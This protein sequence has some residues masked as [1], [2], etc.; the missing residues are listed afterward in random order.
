MKKIVR[1]KLLIL[2]ELFFTVLG[3]LLL[4]FGIMFL[5]SNCS[6]TTSTMVSELSTKIDVAVSEMMLMQREIANLHQKLNLIQANLVLPDSILPNRNGTMDFLA[7]TRSFDLSES[8]F[9][10]N[11]DA[12]IAIVEFTDYECPF[13]KQHFGTTYGQIKEQY[14]DTGM[15]RYY[16]VDFPLDN[17]PFA[18]Q[19]AIAAHCAGAQGVYWN[20]HDRL[21]S[22]R[23]TLS[24]G[25]F[26]EIVES[27]GLNMALFSNCSSD[28][29]TKSHIDSLV[30]EAMGI[31]VS[32]T[33][34]FLIGEVDDEDQ[35]REGIFLQGARPFSAFRDLISIFRF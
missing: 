32:G 14:V 15:A 22:A 7:S 13:C 1:T 17:H 9:Q 5:L 4:I 35:L 10:G 18:F 33:P 28:P 29:E 11:L 27:M 31:G 16:I 25:T 24:S 21:F 3:K 6:T 12:D 19:A 2:S 34:S 20:Y 26:V 23:T 30:A 8:P